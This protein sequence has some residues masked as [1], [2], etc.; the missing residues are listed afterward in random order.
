MTALLLLCRDPGQCLQSGR[1]IRDSYNR[2]FRR[3]FNHSQVTEFQLRQYLMKRTKPVP[4]PSDGPKWTAE[5]KRIRSHLLDNVIFHGWPKEWVTAEPCFENAGV[6]ETG[7]GYRIVKLRYEIVPG[8][9]S[10]AL[11]YEP[12]RLKRRVP[13]ILNVN[14]HVGPMGKAVGV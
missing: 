14:G 5:A 10:S 9:F 7:N 8:F 3:Q 12:S 6:I 13:A 2:C 4:V 1:A 11:L